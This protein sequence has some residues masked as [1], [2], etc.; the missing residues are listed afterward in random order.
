MNPPPRKFQTCRQAA[1][2][3]SFISGESHFDKLWPLS[4]SIGAAPLKF[5][6]CSARIPKVGI[7]VRK[8]ALKVSYVISIQ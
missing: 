3:S 8:N 6:D 5:K 2:L 1:L 4:V 7:V